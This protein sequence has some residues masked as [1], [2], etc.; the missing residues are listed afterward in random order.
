[1]TED[2][3]A[4][5]A[6][7]VKAVQAFHDSH[8][9]LHWFAEFYGTM[10][11]GGFDVL[12]GNPPYV[13]TSKIDYDIK[14]IAGKQ[15][16]I[17][18]EF[19]LRSLDLAADDGRIG[20]IVP[21]SLC[22]SKDFREMRDRL[23]KR[24]PGSLFSSFDNIPAAVFNGVSQRC[25]IW[26]APPG[27][28][29]SAPA[30]TG[31]R[32][33]RAAYRPHLVDTLTYQ[34][35]DAVPDL[36]DSLPRLFHRSASPFCDR[37]QSDRAERFGKRKPSDAIGYSPSARNFLSS[38]ITPPPTIDAKT[39]D[40]VQSNSP[41]EQVLPQGMSKFAALAAL[42]GDACF[43]YWLVWGDGFHV[44]S[45]NVAGFLDW[46]GERCPTALPAAERTGELLAANVNRFLAFKKNAGKYVGNYNFGPARDLTRSLDLA[47]L[48]AADVPFG[49][50]VELFD[51]LD[52]LAAVNAMAGEKNI[53]GWLKSRYPVPAGAEEAEAVLAADLRSTLAAAGYATATELEAITRNRGSKAS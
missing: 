35:V 29:D 8:H 30:A 40:D 18:A 52:R 9:P 22:F 20:M 25:T 31:L 46:F 36:A 6:K 28:S 43:A 1:M 32:R 12:V 21:L 13:R 45:A 34:S 14:W 53:P 23:L 19:L 47:L 15:R 51:A 39:K 44:T 4:A 16:D 7:Y 5:S 38:Y 49:E 27:E 11:R 2:P 24:R 3:D 37:Q 48:H 42:A 33:W 41:S 10:R 26:I 50:A 17:Y